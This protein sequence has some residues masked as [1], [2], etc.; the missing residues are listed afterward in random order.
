MTV[1]E[2]KPVFQ[3][4]RNARKPDGRQAQDGDLVPMSLVRF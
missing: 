1:A 2:T 4:W 3:E